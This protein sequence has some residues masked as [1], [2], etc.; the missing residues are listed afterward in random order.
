M[1]A[2]LHYLRTELP[3]ALRYAFV[4]VAL[5]LSQHAMVFLA[6]HALGVP[7]GLDDYFWLFPIRQLAMLPHVSPFVAIGGFAFCLGISG[8]LALLSL[9]RA[10]RLGRGGGLALGAMIPTLQILAVLIL[11]LLWPHRE[12]ADLQ[13]VGEAV[14]APPYQL[15]IG[16]FAGAALVVVA[17][18]VS[19]AT[20]GAYGWGLFVATPFLVGLITGFLANRGHVRSMGDTIG[21]VAAAGTLGTLA[22]LMLALE[23]LMCVILILP[24]AAILAI[25]G[26]VIGRAAAKHLVDPRQPFYSVA[27]LPL[28][29]LL[30]AAMPPELP[31]ATR[32]AITIDAPP[33]AVWASL[34]ADRRV[35]EA[36]GPVGLAGLAYPV[37]GRIAGTGVGAHR[38]GEFST[39]TADERVTIWQPGRALAFRVVRQPPAME[40]MSPY[41]KLQTPHLVGYFDTGETRFDLKRLTGG[42]TRLT[43]SASHVLRIDPVLYWGPIARWAIGQNVSRVLRD[44]QRDAEARQDK[45]LSAQSRHGQYHAQLAR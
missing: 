24:L 13:R 30:D 7:L 6:F 41:R 27:L 32:A 23:G 15:A 42:R 8:A 16:I 43:V 12:E 19:A 10:A 40:E 22:L 39:G 31:I 37:A 5:I 36:P 34:T 3:A 11:A 18:A 4:A 2:L 21:A 29:F 25:V 17:V 33:E 38:H 35:R 45:G 14:P 9:R 28:I 26:G 44:V 20:M 1:K